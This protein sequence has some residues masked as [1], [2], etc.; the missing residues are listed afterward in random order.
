MPRRIN[1][2]H[3]NLTSAQKRYVSDLAS[4][5]SVKESAAIRFISP[6]TI[7]NTIASAKERVGARTTNSLIAMAVANRWIVPNGNPD[8]W[9]PDD[10]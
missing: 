8:Q 9:K 2:L 3:E 6:F 4:G 10:E 1:L 7:R 5:L